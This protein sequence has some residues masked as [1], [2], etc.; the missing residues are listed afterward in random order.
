MNER[1]PINKRR[2]CFVV[3]DFESQDRMASLIYPAVDRPQGVLYLGVYLGMTAELLDLRA[4]PL[5]W[6]Y[7]GL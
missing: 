6:V 1:R 4:Y 2:S 5:L 7:S 3:T